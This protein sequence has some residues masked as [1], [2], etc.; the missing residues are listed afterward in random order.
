MSSPEIHLRPQWTIVS[1]YYNLVNQLDKLLT[2]KVLTGTLYSPTQHCVTIQ[3]KRILI[4]V[5]DTK[6]N[7]VY[8]VSNNLEAR[9][10]SNRIHVSANGVRSAYVRGNS[11][12]N[13]DTRLRNSDYLLSLRLTVQASGP[14]ST[15]SRLDLDPIVPVAIRCLLSRSVEWKALKINETLIDLLATL[16]VVTVN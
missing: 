13:L 8:T 10:N 9:R 4:A 6:L 11:Q 14:L 12:H 3:V 7:D 2:A 15:L 16:V 5:H 1:D